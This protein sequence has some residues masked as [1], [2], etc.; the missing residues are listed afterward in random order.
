MY[1][2]FIL[3]TPPVTPQNVTRWRT[4]RRNVHQKVTWAAKEINPML[5]CEMGNLVVKVN[6]NEKV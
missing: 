1:F 2:T 4:A 5:S 3:L 6:M